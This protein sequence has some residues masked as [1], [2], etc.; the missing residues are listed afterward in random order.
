[1]HNIYIYMYVYTLHVLLEKG[2]ASCMFFH[3]YVWFTLVKLN[4]SNLLFLLSDQGKKS[5][6]EIIFHQIL[7]ETHR[8]C[9]IIFH[10]FS[11]LGYLL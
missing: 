6:L 3:F 4:W 9:S 5:G 8:P 7:I 1:M 2:G 11:R 10:G